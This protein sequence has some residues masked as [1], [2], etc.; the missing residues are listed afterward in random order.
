MA[1]SRPNKRRFWRRKPAAAPAPE[2]ATPAATPA[3][4]RKLLDASAPDNIKRLKFLLK[5]RLILR[6]LYPKASMRYIVLRQQQETVDTWLRVKLDELQTFGRASRFAQPYISTGLV[7]RMSNCYKLYGHKNDSTGYRACGNL[8]LCPYCYGRA[9]T[10][11]A[12]DCLTRVHAHRGQLHNARLVVMR[13]RSKSLILTDNHNVLARDAIAES[14]RLYKELQLFRRGLHKND[15]ARGVLGCLGKV[16]MDPVFSRQAPI[17]PDELIVAP[18]TLYEINTQIPDMQQVYYNTVDILVV[19]KDANL[20][21]YGNTGFTKAVDRPLQ[22]V[23]QVEFTMEFAKI[24]CYP[25]YLFHN[26]ALAQHMVYSAYSQH[27]HR[28]IHLSG[29]FKNLDRN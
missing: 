18:P 2:T 21:Y 13:R 12:L 9:M 29:I 22:D 24:F 3:V 16:A 10:N 4:V 14:A 26:T 1:A 20:K 23:T 8:L 6:S 25:R 28:H 5:R 27:K 17:N 19:T 15:T 7:N 11:R